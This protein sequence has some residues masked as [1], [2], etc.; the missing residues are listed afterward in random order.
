MS[1]NFLPAHRYLSKPPPGVLLDPTGIGRGLVWGGLL[2]EGSG[3]VANDI[4][5]NANPIA[6]PA[7]VT[8]GKGAFGGPSI[9]LN[10]SVAQSVAARAI[11]ANTNAGAT[12]AAWINPNGFNNTVSHGFNNVG[13]GS[14]LWLMYAG[15]SHIELWVQGSPIA[16]AITGYSTTDFSLMAASINT[17]TKIVTAYL[18]GKNVGTASAPSFAA[19]A[20]MTPFL[21][22][23]SLGTGWIDLP[24]LWNRVL[25]DG[26]HAQLAA[27]PLGLLRGPAVRR[28]YSLGGFTGVTPATTGYTLSGPGT[29]IVGAASSAFT[30]TLTPVNSARTAGTFVVTPS[31]GGAGGT[32]TPASVTV[33]GGTSGNFGAPGVQTGSFT[34]TPAQS[35]AITVTANNAVGFSAPTGT[36]T[37]S[38]PVLNTG[39]V[40]VTVPASGNGVTVACT[41]NTGGFGALTNQWYRSTLAAFTPSV[42]TAIA[43]ATATTLVDTGLVSGLYFYKMQTTDSIGQVVTTLGTPV[44]IQTAPINLV[45]GMIGDSI[46]GNAITSAHPPPYYFRKH[47]LAC[48]GIRAVTMINAGAS[49]TTTNSWLPANGGF[50]NVRTGGTGGVVYSAATDAGGTPAGTNF[51]DAGVSDVHI[52]LGTNDCRTPNQYTQATYQSNLATIIAQLKIDL[53]ATLRRIVLHVPGYPVPG[54]TFNGVTWVEADLARQQSYAV[55]IANLVDNVMVFQGDTLSFSYFSQH[56]E[57][58]GDGIHPTEVGSNSYGWLWAKAASVALFNPPGRIGSW[59]GWRKVLTTDSSG[60]LCNWALSGIYDMVKGDAYYVGISGPT[61]PDVTLISAAIYVDSQS[62][63]NQFTATGQITQ[64]GSTGTYL[65]EFFIQG[66]LTGTLSAT[67]YTWS[68]KLVSSAG[69]IYTPVNGSPL[70]PQASLAV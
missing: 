22:R 32:F 46:A 44:V 2:N 26:E 24:L 31:D 3:A 6:L 35:G 21:F 8:W 37:S 4:S 60:N 19:T 55:A 42:G 48:N 56:Q 30:V 18:N 38:Y 67:N 57:E 13:G 52:M 11:N 69:D 65:V 58:N 62:G 64:D 1:T 17:T 29:V 5:G 49:G 66:S 63:T 51:Q 45:L 16:I 68:V 7:G 34:Y 33:G 23:A 9:K 40:V 61:K 28:L 50:V 47:L 54:S 27:R 43:G 36:V 39:N 12:L 41:G 10:G 15:V 25:D 59:S 20:G 53:V 14:T 70:T